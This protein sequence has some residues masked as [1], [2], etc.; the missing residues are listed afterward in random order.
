MPTKPWK[1]LQVSF[2]INIKYSDF[3]G[4]V[5]IFFYEIIEIRAW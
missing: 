1:E 4:A 2:N 3:T 5:N